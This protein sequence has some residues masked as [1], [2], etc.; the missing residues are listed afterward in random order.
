MNPLQVGQILYGYCGGYF[1]RV[2]YEDKR[3][4]A[5]GAD[6]VVV[7]GVESGKTDFATDMD[8]WTMRR[9]LEYTKKPEEKE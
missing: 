1:D 5:I 4:E 9:L 7:R 3:V 2:E 6:W 8:G